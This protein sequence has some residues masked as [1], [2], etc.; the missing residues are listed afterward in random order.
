M[1]LFNFD[2]NDL[3]KDNYILEDGSFFSDAEQQAI[4]EE[5]M[6][7]DRLIEQAE[8]MLYEADETLLEDTIIVEESVLL[9]E[10]GL[11]EDDD[12]LLLSED[13][14]IVETT[15]A[16]LEA[17]VVKFDKA[18]QL[19]RLL[20]R[21]SLFAA[22]RHD[23]PL[24]RKYKKAAIQKKQYRQ[25]IHRKYEA[26]AKVILKEIL[27]ARKRRNANSTPQPPEQQK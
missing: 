5:S 8:E 17:N 20:K 26:Q 16:L 24:Y 22:K 21:C 25:E 3:E 9:D 7:L 15:E 14:S 10:S 18:T 19:R 4:D 6:E 13:F 2:G 1:K 11:M 23:D 12:D 27:A